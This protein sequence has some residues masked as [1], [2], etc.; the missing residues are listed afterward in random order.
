MSTAGAKAIVSATAGGGGAPSGPASGD[1]SGSYPGP[2]VAQ[3]QGKP[4]ASTAPTDAQLLVWNGSKWTPVSLSG[5]ATMTDTGAVTL[6]GSLPPNGSASGDLSGS[7]PGPT[8]AQIQGKPVASTAPT[9][10]QLLV[11]N[12]S[13]WAPV[14]LSGGVTITDAG[15]ATAT[16]TTKL[17]TAGGT[18]A[19]AIA[20][21]S[22]KITGLAAGTNPGDA[23]NFAQA[24]TPWRATQQGLIA[25]TSDP[26]LV[27]NTFSPTKGVIYVSSIY[28]PTAG[29]V[30]NILYRIT[31]AGTSLVSCYA[32]LMDSSGNVLATTADLST[33][34]AIT[35][36]KY[37]PLSSPYNITTP[38]LYYVAFLVGNST[39][40]TIPV[41]GALQGGAAALTNLNATPVSNSLAGGNRSLSFNSAANALASPSGV[42]TQTQALIFAGLS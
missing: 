32:G 31:T 29:N 28:I 12:G 41:L 8:V 35:G 2:T 17:P 15:V 40:G 4:V 39:S 33:P 30:T 10:A 7:Y 37:T 21:G 19:G 20:M 23:V 16:D 25:V 13:Q 6:S 36:V 42:P 38:G 22:N 3:I 5:G 27:S 18:M 11:W 26:A 9:D 34:W 1:L 14:S 24:S